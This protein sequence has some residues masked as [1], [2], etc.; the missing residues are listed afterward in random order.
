MT[1]PSHSHCLHLKYPLCNLGLSLPPTLL[2]SITLGANRSWISTAHRE[3]TIGI[4]LLMHSQ[5]ALKDARDG[6]VCCKKLQL[7]LFIQIQV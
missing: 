7:G 1:A 4:H 2:P 5:N 6:H 3:M